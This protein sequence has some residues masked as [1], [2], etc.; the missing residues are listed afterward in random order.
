M[1]RSCRTG[2]FA[3]TALVCALLGAAAVR[4]DDESS[5]SET[6]DAI[7][8]IER[9]DFSY[10]S[11][12]VRYE[13]SALQRRI[14]EI[15]HAVGAHA[16]IGVELTCRSGELTRH[17]G[18]QITLAVPVEATAENLAAA[19]AFDTRDELVARVRNEQL[20]SANDIERFP[21][22]WRTVAL[23]RTPPLSLGPA[24]CDLLRAMRDHVF[25]LL[26]VRVVSSGLN[27]G[28]GSDTRIQPKIHVNALMPSRT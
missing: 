14:A 12:T 13:C 24:D 9:I 15:L 22:T 16:R 3:C 20:P 6:I 21:A 26:R 1:N 2:R 25:P 18:A 19:T 23:T 10:H 8:H 17:A 27:C 5:P 28:G 4:A 7:W 11:T